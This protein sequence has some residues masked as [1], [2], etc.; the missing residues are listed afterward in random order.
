MKKAK[1][2]RVPILENAF[3]VNLPK[4]MRAAKAAGSSG[5]VLDDGDVRTVAVLT[6]THL[7]V[8][9]GGR[10]WIVNIVPVPC[11]RRHVRSLLKCPRAHE[12]NFQSLYFEGGELACRH[13]HHLRYRSTLAA[14]ETDRARL[15]RQKLLR[16]MG[17]HSGTMFVERTPF[18][19][20]RRHQRLTA[21]LAALNRL[22]YQ[23]VRAWLASSKHGSTGVT[24]CSSS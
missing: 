4:L 17:G 16:A 19:W 10:T 11:L 22:H 8:L 18:K 7:A 20:R 15:A 21:K 5:L 12:G 1:A 3:E 24:K 9:L 23:G 2:P 14:T 13:C 6:K